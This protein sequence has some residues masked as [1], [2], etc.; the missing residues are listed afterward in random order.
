MDQIV[1]FGWAEGPRYL[2]RV[3]FEVSS[4]TRLV[5]GIHRVLL[6]GAV[7]RSQGILAQT[8]TLHRGPFVDRLLPF[9]LMLGVDLGLAHV[10]LLQENLPCLLARLN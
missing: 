8:G 5:N 3:N 10:D 2:V 6:H 7:R 1:D 4:L 9:D